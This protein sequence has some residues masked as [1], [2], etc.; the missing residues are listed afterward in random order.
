M[1][2]FE[3][4]NDDVTAGYKPLMWFMT[5][6]LAAFVA[7]CGS[8][9]NDPILGGGGAGVVLGAPAGAVIPGACTVAGPKVTTSDPLDGSLSVA[10]ST[11][12]VAG[13]GK[14][15]IA[16]FDTAMDPATIN[17]TTFKLAPVGGVALAPAS[18]SYGA[19]AATF[20][21]AVPLLANTS[22]L[23]IITVGA[24]SA[25]GTPLSCSYAWTFKT[26]A[27]IAAAPPSVN[28]GL[29]APF[30]MAATAGITSTTTTTTINGDVVL[31]ATPTCNGVAAPGGVGSA[32]FGVSG[33][34]CG[35][36]PQ[37]P[38]LTGSVITPTYPDTTTANAVVNDL[39]A[40]FLSITPPAGPPAAG[41][42][43]GATDLPAGTTLGN[44]TGS[45]MVQGDNYFVP[46][47]YQS[48]TSIMISGDL[49]LDAQGDPNARFVFQSSS[50]IGT[51]DGPAPP[52]PGHT[53]ILLVNGAKASNVWWQAATSATLGL[54]SEFQGNILA[55]QTIVMNT[56]ATSCG[57]LLAGAFAAGQFTFDGNVVSVPG[58]PFA[59]P[60]GYS[61][62]C[63]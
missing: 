20:T 50:T 33:T 40:A 37:T 38:V 32:G 1:N 57:R 19:L 62:T 53:R 46:G 22:Y 5:L 16:T 12:G 9:G 45:A 58:Q 56:G 51:A 39:K 10:A 18:V 59:P 60:A 14:K 44:V 23:A 8:G 27:T 36:V 17:A 43:G 21:T 4:V 41:S 25:T 31:T 30:G 61:T 7:G 29:A 52:A 49:T 3:S 42:L 2:R 26:A 6:L 28:L 47:V 55:S 13:N 48:L 11:T 15:I 63:Q 34:A 35:G 24:K 54:Y